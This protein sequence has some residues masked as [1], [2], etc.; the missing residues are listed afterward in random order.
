MASGQTNSSNIKG[1]TINPNTKSAVEKHIENSA[2]FEALQ[3]KM[4]IYLNSGF[5]E[6]FE[7]DSLV[8][9]S[10]TENKVPFK[11]F[12]LWQ[13]NTLIIDGAF[14]IF[15]GIGFEIKIENNEA[16]LSHLLNSDE[17]PS[18]A[19][20]KNDSLIFRLE[21]PCTETKIILSEV[22]EKNKKQIIYGYIEFKSANFYSG[23]ASE[24]GQDVLPRQKLRNNMKLYFKSGYL[25]MN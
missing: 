10:K 7:N 8:F 21:V 3:D 5:V 23:N 17:S 22:P 15:G 20:S 1:L 11:S 19:Y 6:T 12:Y 14:G 25:N 9:T 16:T 13:G 2:D 24:D 18:Y 4:Q